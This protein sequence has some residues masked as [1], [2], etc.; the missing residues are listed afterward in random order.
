MP[1]LG[2]NPNRGLKLERPAAPLTLAVLTYLPEEI[3][4]FEHRFEVTRLCLESLLTNTP[5]NFD[6]LVF[7]NGSCPKMVDHLKALHKED[8]IQYLLLSRHNV[9]K[10]AALRM[11][12]SAAPGE[13]VAY[14]DDDI[15]FLPGWLETHMNI[16]ETYP[17]VGLVTGF[18]IRSHLRYGTRSLEAFAS[19][20]D[21][22]VE[23]GQLV[24]REIEQHYAENMGRTWEQYLEEVKGLQDMRFTY[25]DINALASSGHHQFLAQRDVLLEALPREKDVLLMGRMVELESRIDELGYL[26]LSTEPPV[27][28]LLGNL[29]D[30]KV[31]AVSKTFD[32]SARQSPQ[33]EKFPE[34]PGGFIQ[35]PPVRRFL[36]YLYNRLHKVLF[37][38]QQ[39]QGK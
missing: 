14:T 27:T 10:L 13:L 4:Y 6:L 32:I 8:K 20:A 34:K 24:S 2:M 21:V 15:F 28:L 38:S 25:H 16:M 22:L 12:F 35:S 5:A 26:R 1:R 7:D 37:S 36:Q 31:F 39:E 9:G 33:P 19:R 29:L 23:R 30:E 17:K 18:Y 3:G 11:I